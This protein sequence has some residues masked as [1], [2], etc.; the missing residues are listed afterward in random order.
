VAKRDYYEVLGVGSNASEEEIRKAY[1]KMARQYHPDVNK[2]AG[3]E[4]KFKE[5]QEAYEVLSDQQKRAQYDQFGHNDSFSGGF[6]SGFDAQDFGFGDIFDMFFFFFCRR[7]PNAAC[8]GASLE[9]RLEVEFENAVFGKDIDI[10]IPRT[11]ECGRCHGSGAKPG[12]KAETC[13]NCKG[14]G[15]AEIVQNT[16]F[17]RI[18]NRRVCTQCK[19]QGKVIKSPCTVCVGTGQIKRNKTINVK[20]PAGINEGAQLRI[21]GEG[22]AGINGGPPGDLYISIF[23]KAH[24]FFDREGD[25]LTCVLP[26]TFAQA[27][28]GDEVVVPTLEGKAKLKVPQGTQTGTEFRMQGK[29]V[30]RLRGFGQGDLRIR[31]KVIVPK[32][33]NDEQKEVLRQFNELYRDVVHEQ[34]DNFF[35]K[36]KKAFRG[37]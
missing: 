14:T 27:A 32:K 11:E 23:V 17:G 3:A 19:G 26:I 4:Q 34:S 35:E 1:R 22:E 33:L 18:V 29:G 21:A 13:H 6:T 30:P 25:D 7:N 15:Q 28:L 12:T 5:A 24:E 8:Q 9:Y 20:I 10:T 37:D 36:M 2:E 31:V 16:P